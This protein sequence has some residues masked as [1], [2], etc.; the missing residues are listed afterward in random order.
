MRASVSH[1]P[2]GFS[3]SASVAERLAPSSGA[4]P[5]RCPR[6]RV[7]STL[8]PRPPTMRSP[9]R[10]PFAPATGLPRC[11]IVSTIQRAMWPCFGV[12]NG[13]GSETAGSPCGAGSR[14]A[15]GVRN[16][17]RTDRSIDVKPTCSGACPIEDGSISSRR[18]DWLCTVPRQWLPAGGTQALPGREC[19]EDSTRRACRRLCLW[20]RPRLRRIGD[21]RWRGSLHGGHPE[22]RRVVLLQDPLGDRT[23]LH[24][25]RR[26]HC[27]RDRKPERVATVQRRR[28]PWPTPTCIALSA[29]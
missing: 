23:S 6:R 18:I 14:C 3:L 16:V 12:S 26:N 9:W 27:E 28:V 21:R 29:G 17:P 7:H 10:P 8:P 24:G 5:S 11:T 20:R 2:D 22:A 25:Q 19:P 13:C 4:P 1:L 15:P